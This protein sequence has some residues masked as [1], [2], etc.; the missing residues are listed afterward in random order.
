MK[1]IYFGLLAAALPFM[2]KAVESVPYQTDFSGDEWVVTDV[3]GDYKTW[4]KE[5]SGFNG[6]GFSKGI[7]Y[8]YHSSN[9]ANDW[10]IGPAVH[11]EAGKE[12]KIKYWYKAHSSTY[13]E[14]YKIFLS[15]SNDLEAMAATT[16]IKDTSAKGVNNTTWMKD[17]ILYTPA[18]DGDYYIG[19]YC[20]SDKD[21]F[22]LYMTGFSIAENVFAP[23]AP[24]NLTVTPG[25]NE[26][27]EATLTWALP[28]KDVDDADLP[29]GATHDGTNIYRDGTFVEMAGAGATEWTDDASKGLTAGKHLYEI[30]AIVNGARSAKASLQSKYIGPIGA[31]PLPYDAL[32]Q[33]TDQGKTEFEEFWRWIHGTNSEYTNDWSFYT[34][35]Y[36]GQYIKFTTNSK[37]MDEFLFSPKLKFETPGIYIIKANISSSYPTATTHTT[38]TFYLSDS[39][40]NQESCTAP[41]GSFTDTNADA[42]IAFRVSSPVEKYVALNFTSPGNNSDINIKDFKVETWHEAPMLPTDL[43]ADVT[44]DKSSVV[45]T[46]KNPSKNNIDED[47]T[48]LSKVEIYCDGT[49]V[50]TL[51]TGI[52]PGEV[53]SYT[54]TPAETGSHKYKAVPYIGE[55][56]PDADCPEINSK[57]V[58]DET[59]EVPYYTSFANNDATRFIWSGVDVDADDKTW[60]LTEQGS[61]NRMVLPNKGED[62]ATHNDY[63]LSPYF[64][65]DEGYYHI[66]F[67]LRGGGKNYVLTPGLVSDK[68]NVAATFTAGTEF[69]LTGNTYDNDYETDLKVTAPGKYSFALLAAPT[70]AAEGPNVLAA[71]DGDIAIS[72]VNIFKQYIKPE[73]PEEA[74]ATEAPNDELKVTVRWKNPTTSNVAGVEPVITKAIVKRYKE[75][76]NTA[77]AEYTIEATAE[78][79]MTP[80]EFSE[81]VDAEVPAPG[82]YKYEIQLYNGD[83]FDGSKN[84]KVYTGYVGDPGQA[85]IS[86]KMGTIDCANGTSIA[87]KSFADGESYYV[88]DWRSYNLNGDERSDGWGDYE[89]ITFERYSNYLEMS[90]TNNTVNDDWA[91]SPY[92]KFTAGQ[93]YKLTLHSYRYGTSDP[94]FEAWLGTSLTVSN[95]ENSDGSVTKHPEMIHKLAAVTVNTSSSTAP[96]VKE[97]IIRAVTQAEFD[98]QPAA[99]PAKAEGDE[100]QPETVV[101]PE[102][103][104]TMGLWANSAGSFYVNGVRVELVANSVELPDEDLNIF[105]G[106]ESTL[107]PTVTGHEL[108]SDVITWKSLNPEIAT[109]DQTGKVTGVAV[110]ET[111]IVASG[112]A[113]SDMI[114]VKVNPILAESVTV[115]APAEEMLIGATMELTAVVA[116][117]NTTDKTLVWS[118][119]DEEIATV[120]ETGKVT[121]VAVGTVT[122]KAACGE[123]FGEV[124]ITVKPILATAVTITAPA[125]EL[126][127]GETMQLTAEVAP[128]NTTDKT[129]V[130]SSSDETVATVDQT[131]LVSAVKVGNVT[132]KAA[133]GEIF[134]EVE[135]TVKPVLASAVTVTAPAEDM[136]E[137]ETMQLTAVVDPEATDDKTLVWSSSDESVAT[138]DQNGLVTAV[139][140]GDVTIS[141]ACGEVSGSVDIHVKKLIIPATSLTLD[142]TEITATLGESVQLTA[143]VGPEN[144]TDKTVAWSSSDVTIA[145]VDENGLVTI[146]GIGDAVITAKCG[147][148]EATCQVKALSS[149]DMIFADPSSDARIFNL[150]GIEVSRDNLSP[151]FYIITYMENGVQVSKKVRF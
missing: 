66:R 145:T 25:E 124:E 59:Q 62:G 144:A 135:L 127:K 44:A 20:C 79:P 95:Q 45:F 31:M 19:I 98:A 39:N 126:I 50:E 148:L 91:V 110:G 29:E 149:I 115:T 71:A 26:A 68:E 14:K 111:D 4:T 106:G 32:I 125:S 60:T 46:W 70:V 101:I 88:T 2:A 35:N 37:V 89:D 84:V 7:K 21:R 139:A 8:T 90:G 17:A 82:I 28:T 105:I 23:G 94:T 11:L 129:L 72:Q 5:S 67:Q 74:T 34:S 27:L 109:V 93:T 36:S 121:A 33:D 99:A 22:F 75:A 131:G 53:S 77:Q 96:T 112:A 146:V 81:Y 15:T 47:I 114:H 118:S 104:F 128:E 97:V 134:G 43:T 38:T 107:E 1:K 113:A 49:L 100:A 117:E 120:D 16:P 63:A 130:W 136:T 18:A 103:K 143:T 58:G 48:A 3:N 137:G 142:K 150:K 85:T 73:A 76:S 41:L 56:A 69:K 92:M 12:Y 61:G 123:I 116:P 30:E 122:I 57:W 140:E 52:N 9:A 147:D 141:A 80:G 13:A 51:T 64:Q 54:H 42:K 55:N 86:Y 65:L 83:N 132:I 6:T 133:C 119:S 102:G 24:T 10:I 87:E 108:R 40:Q 151:G 138:V 78:A